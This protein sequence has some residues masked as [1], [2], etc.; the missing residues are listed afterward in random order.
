MRNLDHAI[1]AED[2]QEF[3]SE[4]DMLKA[5]IDY[6]S[7]DRSVGSGGIVFRTAHDAEQACEQYNGVVVDGRKVYMELQSGHPKG[8][9]KR[10]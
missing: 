5:W 4:F 3:F 7:T 6:D 10:K 9:G 2:L 8:K 1:M